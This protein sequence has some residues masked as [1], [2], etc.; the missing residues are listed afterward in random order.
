MQLILV[1]SVLTR[2]I[3][4]TSKVLQKI[5]IYKVTVLLDKVACI[6]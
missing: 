1:S 3:D 4:G 6:R 2:K 5:N